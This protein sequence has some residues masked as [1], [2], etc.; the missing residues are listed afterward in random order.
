MLNDWEAFSLEM[1]RIVPPCLEHSA[2]ASPKYYHS[3]HLVREAAF[4]C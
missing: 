4:N 1:R 3:L 2:L